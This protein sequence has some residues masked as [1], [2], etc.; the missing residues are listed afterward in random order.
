LLRIADWV[1]PGHVEGKE[2][3][4]LRHSS[5]EH[6]DAFGQTMFK[7]RTSIGLRQ[8]GLAALLWV[9]RRDE[10]RDRR[11]GKLIAVQQGAAKVAGRAASHVC[12]KPA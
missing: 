2:H 11:R 12:R 6:D 8:A 3:A 4:M 5:R 10:G 1:L 7:L 9:S